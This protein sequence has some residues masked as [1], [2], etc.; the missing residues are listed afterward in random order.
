MNTKTDISAAYVGSTGVDK[1]CLGN[2][3]VWEN[4]VPYER[5]YLTIQ[6]LEQGDFT[7]RRPDISYSVN[8]GPWVAITGATTISL[9]QDDTV[10]FKGIKTGTLGPGYQAFSANTLSFITY[11][12]VESLEYGD[13]FVGQTTMLGNFMRCFH[14]CPNLADVSN[15][16]LPATALTP[17]SY[18]AMFYDCSGITASPVLPAPS[19]PYQGY[20]QM[21]YGCT[22]LT[23]ITCYATEIHEDGTWRW[24]RYVAPSGTFYRDENMYDWNINTGDPYDGIPENWTVVPPLE[25]PY[26]KQYFTVEANEAGTFY[27]RDE[28]FLFSKNGGPWTSGVGNTAMT[29]SQGDKVRFKHETNSAYKGMFSG[30][31]MSFKVYGNI[32]SMEYGDNFSGQTSIHVVSAFTQYFENCTGLEDAR[33]LILPATTLADFCYRDMFTSC[34]SLTTAPELPATT[35]TSSCYSGM[36]FN[37]TSLTTAP[38]LP[39][40]TLA[41]GCYVYMFKLC[42]SLTASPVLPATTLASECYYYMF[43]GCSSLNTITCFATSGINTGDTTNNWVSGVAR[44]GTFYKDANTTWPTGANGIP[45]GWTVQDYVDPAAIPVLKIA[46][47][48]ITGTPGGGISYVWGG[49]GSLSGTSFTIEVLGVPVTADTWDYSENYIDECGE[50]SEISH[51][52]GTTVSVFEVNSGYI[53]YVSYDS[54]NNFVGYSSYDDHTSDDPEFICNCQGGCW[55]G[56]TCQEC[57]PEDPCDDYIGMGYS[58]YE[59]CKCGMGYPEYCEEPTGDICDDWE[60]NG[61]SSYEECTCANRGENCPEEESGE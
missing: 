51:D 17:N 24:D 34:T 9:D 52:T 29:L 46:G 21:F 19:V 53:G 1:L 18:Y 30:N 37:C 42:R 20:R 41:G 28:N 14:S 16:I 4:F 35:L 27:A 47:Q 12:N 43:E 32:E 22:S 57:E 33:N 40:T 36:F 8:K 49:L 26:E 25:V 60:G 38:E 11:G 7:I 3:V 31:T 45:S 13:N 55:D 39:A 48:S 44:R 2:E 6:A 50:S 10:R 56:E 5:Q 54:S 59:E 15:L 23:A 58:S 61:Y